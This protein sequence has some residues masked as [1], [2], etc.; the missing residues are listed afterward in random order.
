MAA[1]KLISTTC[2]ALELRLTANTIATLNDAQISGRGKGIK[3]LLPRSSRLVMAT[4]WHANEL[5]QSFHV[6]GAILC[7]IYIKAVANYY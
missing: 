5:V 6:N 1:M 7:N 2:T 4:V 3:V